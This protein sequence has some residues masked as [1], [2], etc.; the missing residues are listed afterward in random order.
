MIKK[1]VLNKLGNYNEKFKYS[2]DYKLM[3]DL[4]ESKYKIKIINT[5][6]YKLNTV[7]NISSNKKKEQEYYAKCIRKK[8]EPKFYF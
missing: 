1:S 5:P 3:S 6:L 7:N 8:I 2:Q 4:I